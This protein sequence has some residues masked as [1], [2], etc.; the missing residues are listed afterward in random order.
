MKNLTMISLTTLAALAAPT[1][2]T[3]GVT[4]PAD[5]PTCTETGGKDDGTNPTLGTGQLVIHG[6]GDAPV[7]LVAR[8]EL[9]A[10]QTFEAGVP[11]SVLSGMWCIATRLGEFT[12]Q[13]DCVMVEARQI[14][15]YRLGAVTFAR[16]TNEV[17]WGVDSPVDPLLLDH[18]RTADAEGLLSRTGTIAHAAGT[19]KY[20]AHQIGGVEFD[21]R[22]GETTSVFLFSRFEGIQLTPPASRSLPDLRDLGDSSLVPALCSVGTNVEQSTCL[23][24]QSSQTPIWVERP[25]GD[26]KLILAVGTGWFEKQWMTIDYRAGSSAQIPLRRIDLEHVKVELTDGAVQVVPGV[27]HVQLVQPGPFVTFKGDWFVIGAPTGHG[28]DVFPGKYNVLTVFKHPE[29]GAE[30]TFT[31]MMDLR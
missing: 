6:A 29:T 9:G 31:R 13:E 4:C 2:C 8:R 23:E 30:M 19:A 24:Y 25:R 16:P 15:E 7:E 28:L 12:T 22:P 17:V 27:A 11:Q 5:D 21:V 20:R 14:T 10:F 26:E 3:D 1:G 18:R